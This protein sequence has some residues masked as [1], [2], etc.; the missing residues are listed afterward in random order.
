MAGDAGSGVGARAQDLSPRARESDANR[1][2]RGVR[3]RHRRYR[4]RRHQAG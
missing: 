1:L 3:P 2:Q 4:Q